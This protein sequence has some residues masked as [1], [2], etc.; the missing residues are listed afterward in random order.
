MVLQQA[1]TETEKPKPRILKKPV[2]KRG[3]GG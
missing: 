2:E 1:S 3:V